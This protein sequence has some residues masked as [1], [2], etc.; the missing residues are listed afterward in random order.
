M[1]ATFLCEGTEMQ[2]EVWINEESFCNVI[3]TV[4]ALKKRQ[5]FDYQRR[6]NKNDLS[7]LCSPDVREC[8]ALPAQAFGTGRAW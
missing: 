3:K 2:A 1:F 8:A 4:M 5:M 6:D 7:F